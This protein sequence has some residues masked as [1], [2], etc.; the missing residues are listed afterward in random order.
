VCQK[1]IDPVLNHSAAAVNSCSESTPSKV[2]DSLDK[3]PKEHG[4]LPSNSSLSQRSK[5]QHI[6]FPPPSSKLWGEVE[7]ELSVILPMLFTRVIIARLDTQELIL[8][9]NDWLYHFFTEKFGIKKETAQKARRPVHKDRRCVRIRK[10]KKEVRRE[11]RALLKKG[12]ALNH[13]LVQATAKAYLKLVRKHN[14]IR[15]R[16]LKRAKNNVFSKN[17]KSFKKDPHAFAKKLFKD[18]SSS[19]SPTF[20]KEEAEEFFQK[21]Y[22]DEGRDHKFVPLEGMTRPAL[23][24]HIFDLVQPTLADLRRIVRNKRNKAS[25]GFNGIS[26]V[27]YKKC[28]SILKILHKIFIKIWKSRKVPQEWATAFIILLSKSNILDDPSEFRPIA[29]T[30]CYGDFLFDTVKNLQ[31]FLVSNNYIDRSV[32]KGFLSGVSGCLEYPFALWEAL[33]EAKEEQRQIHVDRFS[34]CVW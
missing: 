12:Y 21:T 10:Q 19:A 16:I 34:Q 28:E 22:R 8:K 17:T 29:L 24:D 1:S 27:P 11:H 7:S 26:Y 32:Q 20:S 2:P 14:Q 3:L 6:D 15:K 31:S 23:P 13:P 18:T 25:P 33:K 9:F 5:R 4:I 30:N